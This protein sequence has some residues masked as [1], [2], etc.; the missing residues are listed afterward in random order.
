VT[1]AQPPP[2]TGGCLSLARLRAGIVNRDPGAGPARPD[3]KGK[4]RT[5]VGLLVQIERGRDRKRQQI[6]WGLWSVPRLP[7]I[8]TREIRQLLLILKSKFQHGP[9]FSIRFVQKLEGLK[10]CSGSDFFKI[11]S[12]I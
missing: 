12:N 10:I 4:M 2:P 5:H 7:I 11:C 3:R 8:P 9:A 1:V 6:W